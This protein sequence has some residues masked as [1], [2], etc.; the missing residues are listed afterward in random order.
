MEGETS[1]IYC[2]S[3]SQV[4]RA[5]PRGMVK[6]QHSQGPGTVGI[7]DAGD[8]GIETGWDWL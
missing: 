1:T 5:R 2:H 6:G 8:T 4:V 3:L 7:P